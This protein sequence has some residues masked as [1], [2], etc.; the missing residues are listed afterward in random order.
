MIIEGNEILKATHFGIIKI[1]EKDLKCAVLEDGTRILNKATIFTAFG[2]QP[3]GRRKDDIRVPSK[4]NLPSFIDAKNLAPFITLEL[5]NMLVNPIKYKTKNGRIV[6]GYSAEILPLLCDVYLEARMANKLTAKQLNIAKASEILVRS[7]SKVGIVALVDE[8]TGY[9]RDR[10]REELQKI[11]SLYISK[12]LLPWTKTFPDEFYKQMFRL[13]N[14]SYPT[15]DAKRPGVVGKYTNKYVYDM[16]PPGVKEDLQKRNP[17]IKPGRRKNKLFQYLS[18]D[19]G[20]QHLRE[21]LLQVIALMK[22]SS[23]WEQFN[24]LFNRTFNTSEQTHFKY[25][26]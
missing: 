26:K 13:K 18:K 6:D 8:A 15:P 2:R 11:L 14:W 10:D 9:Q 16:L 24:T 4:P 12:E 20:Y 25:D 23:D 7:L 21:H 1:G 3:G 22:A 17:I 19:V 5:E